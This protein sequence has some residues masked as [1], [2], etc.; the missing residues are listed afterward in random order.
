LKWLRWCGLIWV[1]AFCQDSVGAPRIVLDY[2]YDTAGFFNAERRE[3]MDMAADSINRW[4]D[5]LSPIVESGGNTWVAQYFRPD[6]G[7]GVVIPA[8]SGFSVPAND[9][10]V[11]VGARDLG[12]PYLAIAQS[13]GAVGFG[14]QAWKDT[15]SYRGQT[16]G[17]PHVDFGPWSSSVAF[18]TNPAIDWYSQANPTQIGGGQYDLFTVAAHELLHV[19]GFGI[20]PSYF[21]LAST[22]DFVGP[23][24][25]AAGSAS[26]P[27]LTLSA[28]GDHWAEGTTGL[29]VGQQQSSIITPTIWPGSR[30]RPTNLDLA[31]VDDLG[32]QAALSGDL[33]RDRV[34]DFSDAFTFVS[35]YGMQHTAGWSKGDF[36]GDGHVTFDDA[37]EMVSNYGASYA[38]DAAAMS[39]EPTLDLM[40]VAGTGEVQAIGSLPSGIKALSITSASGLLLVGQASWLSADATF[41]EDS[42]STTGFATLTALGDEFLPQDSACHPN[43]CWATCK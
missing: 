41:V 40:Y 19:F 36:N 10:R 27:S 24:A 33:N 11:Y 29:L 20:A 39:I 14:T 8:G 42:G 31:A 35:Y 16:P 12:A 38:T 32:W 25:I 28:G 18:N 15:V 17:P 30:L 4:V 5:T 6:T 3:V 22:G 2:S 23:K 21:S 37:F 1:L 9:I 13:S 34:V 26:N 43:F 7:V